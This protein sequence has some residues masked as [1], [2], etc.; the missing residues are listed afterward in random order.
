[1]R[2]GGIPQGV[3]PLTLVHP[4]PNQ[5]LTFEVSKADYKTATETVVLKPGESKRV[6]PVKLTPLAGPTA[7]TKAKLVVRSSPDGAAVFSGPNRLGI[8]PLEIP[9]LDVSQTYSL[10]LV[11]D[12]YRDYE[13]TVAFQGR[14]E[15]V[16]TA[17]L[18]RE[19]KPGGGR[20]P[21]A[22]GGAAAN[23]GSGGGGGCSGSGAKL[24]VNARGVADCR[25][26]VGKAS[27]G[28]PPFFN[29][30]APVGKCE[31]V[32]TCPDGKK[33]TETRVLK[34]GVAEKLIIEQPMWK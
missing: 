10:R 21:P 23:G 20:K 3:T 26:T 29:K 4:G 34:G 8:T 15:A 28:V 24:S 33:Y 18:E 30:D 16:V 32:V 7:A 2:V 11:K 25:V 13:T 5:A 22:G 19:H 1:V 17:E 6:V 9:E 12:G 31:I 14:A 27:L